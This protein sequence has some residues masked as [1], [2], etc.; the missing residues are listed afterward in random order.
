MLRIYDD[1]S[2]KKYGLN[3]EFPLNNSRIWIPA[4]ISKH[5]TQEMLL[6]EY[7]VDGYSGFSHRPHR[8]QISSSDPNDSLQRNRRRPT[9]TLSL[10]DRLCNLLLSQTSSRTWRLIQVNP[11]GMSRATIL[12][13]NFI[14]RVDPSIQSPS[15]TSISKF[16]HNCIMNPPRG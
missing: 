12:P 5:I 10:E 13:P 8:H 7:I 1:Q 14:R 11:L 6:S 16:I 3:P 15:D 9:R 4:I 2:Y